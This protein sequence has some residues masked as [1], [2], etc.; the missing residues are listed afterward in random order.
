[1]VAKT[2]SRWDSGSAWLIYQTLEAATG[3]P[4]T[5]IYQMKDL[6]DSLKK[7][8]NLIMVAMPGW[9]GSTQPTAGAKSWVTRETANAEHGDRL[10]INGN[11]EQSLSV[12]ASDF[13][14]RY[15]KY[16][17]DS[18]M[19]RIPLTDKPIDKGADPAALP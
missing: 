11:D 7:S 8:G 2:N 14:L 17:K 18:G 9:N 15:W 3:R 19:R 1:M 16:A 12:A 5:P 10:I 4:V 6:P 13:V